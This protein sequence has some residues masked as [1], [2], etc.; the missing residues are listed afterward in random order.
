MSL[1]AYTRLPWVVPIILRPVN[2]F[3]LRR[4]HRHSYQCFSAPVPF[5]PPP[6]RKYDHLSIRSLYCT[7]FI[8]DGLLAYDFFLDDVL[9]ML[10]FVHTI[11]W[12]NTISIPCGLYLIWSLF[13]DHSPTTFCHMIFCDTIFCPVPFV[14]YSMGISEWPVPAYWY[15][16]LTQLV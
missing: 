13:Y 2:I 1:N 4:L 6:L 10:Y 7:I 11:R 9:R 16:V 12:T 14:C 8:T 5:S 3:T 15:I